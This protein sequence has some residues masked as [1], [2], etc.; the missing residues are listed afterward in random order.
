M[1]TALHI[2][3]RPRVEFESIE[4]DTLSADPY[5]LDARPHFPVEA[6]LVHA[7]IPGRIAQ[8]N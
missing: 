4:R 2:F 7:E 8:A 3:V 5:E 6:V 1:S